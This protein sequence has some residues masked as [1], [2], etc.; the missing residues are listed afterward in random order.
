MQ[1]RWIYIVIFYKAYARSQN[2]PAPPSF[3]DY[4]LIPNNLAPDPSGFLASCGSELPADSGGIDISNLISRQASDSELLHTSSDI[5][6]LEDPQTSDDLWGSGSVGGPEWLSDLTTDPGQFA[7]NENPPKNDRPSSDVCS[8]EPPAEDNGGWKPPWV[9]IDPGQPDR[10]CLDEDWEKFCCPL[11]I[12]PLAGTN[13]CVACKA[14]SPAF[15]SMEI[16]QHH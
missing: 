7:F 15:P 11:G 2:V 1:H 14:S 12:V 8:T 5:W 13:G 4:F 3:S 16:C 9:P 10:D 6:N